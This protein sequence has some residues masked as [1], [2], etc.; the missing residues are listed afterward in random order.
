MDI[1][2]TT[3]A[4]RSSN[5]S[6]P[7]FVAFGA[8]PHVFVEALVWLLVPTKKVNSD[9]VKLVSEVVDDIKER[10]PHGLVDIEVVIGLF[11]DYGVLKPKLVTGL[12]LG[13]KFIKN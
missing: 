10:H 7:N 5:L 11:R 6:V 4:C 2:V 13:W 12:I 1:T 8:A 9:M 3:L